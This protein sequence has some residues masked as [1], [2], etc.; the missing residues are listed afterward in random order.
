MNK[1][2]KQIDDLKV[3]TF[4]TLTIL[5][6]TRNAEYEL[7]VKYSKTNIIKFTFRSRIAPAWNG[8]SLIS[9]NT[10]S[11]LNINKFKNLLDR[12]PNLS[13]NKFDC[14][15]FFFSFLFLGKL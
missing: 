1:I 9:I 4:F 7:Y 11:A 13:V 10:K 12:D 2:I 5:D 8:L 15:S 14:D 3:D 6:I